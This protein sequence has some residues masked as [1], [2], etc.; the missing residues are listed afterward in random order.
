[1]MD[2]SAKRKSTRLKN[3]DYSKVGVYF[4]TVC[5]EN[6]RNILGSIVG[7]GFPLPRLSEY[8]RI[9]DDII[10][11]L[12]LKYDAISVDYYV[13]MPNHIHLMVAISHGDG[14]G[15]PSPTLSTVIGWLKYST[16]KKINEISRSTGQKVFQRSFYD[17][18]IRN[19]RDYE[20]HIRYIHD[21]PIRWKFDELYME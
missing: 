21:N 5:T 16:T 9:V 3:Y 4:V 20:E 11:E 12:P 2:N 15:N 7:E 8:G 19:R 13:I 1:M 10:K 18:V 17:H 14:R 6:Q